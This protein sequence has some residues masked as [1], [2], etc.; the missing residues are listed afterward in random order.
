MRGGCLWD[1]A[2]QFASV[3]EDQA[4]ER[5]ENSKQLSKELAAKKHKVGEG[6]RD[7]G[8]D[9]QALALASPDDGKLDVALRDIRKIFV[10]PLSSLL[11]VRWS[12]SSSFLALC[13]QALGHFHCPR[14]FST[15]VGPAPLLLKGPL[16]G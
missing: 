15:A 3:P 4:V 12:R 8:K 9:C 16:A 11:C 13:L 7:K 5:G 1:A 10:P 6:D 2:E 14:A